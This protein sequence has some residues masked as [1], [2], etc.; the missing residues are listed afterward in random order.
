MGMDF[1]QNVLGLNYKRMESIF[2]KCA[3]EYGRRRPRER[4]EL[5]GNGSPIIKMPSNT[6]AVKGIR[7][8]VLPTYPRFIQDSF[9]P[10]SFEFDTITKIL[11]VFPPSTTM[12]VTY[13]TGLNITNAVQISYSQTAYEGESIVEDILK[14]HFKQ[15]TLKITKNNLEMIEVSREDIASTDIDE[16]PIVYTQVNLSGTLGTGT[17]NL[18]TREFILN[19]VDTSE[20]ELVF[21]YYPK[22]KVI[23]DLD[24]IGDFIFYTLFEYNLLKS[25]AVLRAQ[26]TQPDLHN[27]DLTIDD[28]KARVNELRVEVDKLLKSSIKFSSMTDI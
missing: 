22:Y 28:L 9:D 8:Y 13:L 11:K 26:V 27:I 23:T 21:T 5:M 16:N 10:I 14:S 15:G 6:L 18:N 7:Y 4:A 17:I 2:T 3:L 24:N 19:L 25:I 1:I 20:G 12:K